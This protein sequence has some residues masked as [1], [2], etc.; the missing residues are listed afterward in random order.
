MR[1]WW[2]RFSG[3]LIIHVIMQW[4]CCWKWLCCWWDVNWCWDSDGGTLL[5]PRYIYLSEPRTSVCLTL[6]FFNIQVNDL[7]FFGSDHFIGF[8]FFTYFFI[9][10]R[11][12]NLFF[13][14]VCS[15]C[16]DFFG[17]CNFHLHQITQEWASSLANHWHIFLFFNC[18]TQR[19]T[20]GCFG[21]LIFEIFSTSI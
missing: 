9:R 21:I 16:L 4:K 5:M 12:K 6:D 11:V 1:A 19:V 20:M 13:W 18:M 3:H 14:W 8:C 17:W 15:R 7:G 10:W 2:R